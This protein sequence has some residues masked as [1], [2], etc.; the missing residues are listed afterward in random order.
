MNYGEFGLMSDDEMKEVMDFVVSEDFQAIDV[1]ALVPTSP[2]PV[3]AFLKP[4]M[5]WILG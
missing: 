3:Y 2:I 4:M 1:T 5:A